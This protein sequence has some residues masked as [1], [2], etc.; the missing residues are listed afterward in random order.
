M[1]A[2]NKSPSWIA[3]LLEQALPGKSPDSR[4]PVALTC[5]YARPTMSHRLGK[6]L[7][8]AKLFLTTESKKS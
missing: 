1:E 3:A 2:L 4:E 8:W 6:S 7:C 5:K